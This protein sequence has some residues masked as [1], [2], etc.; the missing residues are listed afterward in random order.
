MSISVS[1]GSATIGSGTISGVIT[2]AGVGGVS[3]VTP[4]TSTTSFVTGSATPVSK[5]L[6]ASIAA[7]VAAKLS[8]SPSSIAALITP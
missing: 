2:G 1:G 7:M 6:P 5:S 3:G 8:S 4:V